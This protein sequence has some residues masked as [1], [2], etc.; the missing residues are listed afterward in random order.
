MPYPLPA[1][2]ATTTTTTTTS[3]LNSNEVVMQAVDGSFIGWMATY[4]LNTRTEADDVV[5]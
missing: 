5:D 3:S 4:K 1:A 2:A